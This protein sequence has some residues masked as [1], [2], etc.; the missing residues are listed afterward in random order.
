MRI[1]RA[2]ILCSSL[3]CLQ[4]LGAQ[5]PDAS[6]PVEPFDCLDQYTAAESASLDLIPLVP[7]GERHAMYVLN[8]TL[9]EAGSVLLRESIASDRLC[10]PVRLAKL[11]VLTAQ[12]TRRRDAL[13]AERKAAW[14]TAIEAA[15]DKA[16]P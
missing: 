2:L 11:K 5:V 4:Q 9:H 1:V 16:V 13:V 3:A 10:A 15:M 14:I 7:S 12:M 8:E 6:A